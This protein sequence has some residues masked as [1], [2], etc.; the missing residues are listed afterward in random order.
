MSKLLSRKLS[1]VALIALIVTSALS[2]SASAASVPVTI[3]QVWFNDREV[4]SGDIRGDVLRG[5]SLEVEVKLRALADTDNVRVAVDMEGDDRADIDERTEAF[6]IKAGE[7]YYKKVTLDLPENLDLEDPTS[8]YTVHIEISNR[9]DERVTREFVIDV[10]TSR[11]SIEIDDVIFNP[12]LTVE[13]GRSLLA[14][15]R[16]ENNGEKDEEDVKVTLSVEGMGSDADY[17]DEIESNDEKMSEQLY[18]PIPVCAAANT[19]TARVT[20]DYD[21]NTRQ[22][23]KEFPV[24]VLASDRCAQSTSGDQRTTIVVGPESQNIVAGG[25]EAVY[26]V[27]LTNSGTQSRTY[28]V[29]L[30]AGTDLEARVSPNVVVVAPGETKVAYAYVK[31]KDNASAGEKTFSVKVSSGNEMLKEVMLKANIVGSEKTS[32][33]QGLQIGLVVLVVLLVIVGLIVG[34]SRLKGEES[35][36]EEDETYY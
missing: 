36:K 35:G 21:E 16:V 5:D 31:A 12:G 6:S 25:N 10:A 9:N 3:E 32:L 1:V 33:V 34:F 23:S 22:E 28:V 8:R 14:S 20:V 11:H 13:A 17:I 24:T 18:V 29:E 15:V 27:Q 19:Y 4:T 7:V 2:L 26:P 30:T